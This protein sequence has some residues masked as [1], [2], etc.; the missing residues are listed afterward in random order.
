MSGGG[1]AS[2]GEGS[3]AHLDLLDGVHDEGVLQILHGPLHPVVEGCS[4]LGILQVQLVNGLQQFLCPLGM[5]VEGRGWI[6]GLQQ[7]QIQNHH[8]LLPPP[9]NPQG[10]PGQ[11]QGVQVW[12]H[13]TKSDRKNRLSLGHCF[14]MWGLRTIP[15]WNHPAWP[16]VWFVNRKILQGLGLGCEV[17]WTMR[18]RYGQ[19]HKG[20]VSI[21]AKPNPAP[22]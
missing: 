12:K 4:P 22:G 2:R 20:G 3:A 17:H 13:Q 21:K 16:P 6:E 7:S 8:S 9:L 18:G 10:P 19:G 1:A 15:H 14:L 5:A 11:P